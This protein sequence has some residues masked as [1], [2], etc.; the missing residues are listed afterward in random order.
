MRKVSV[1]GVSSSRTG[2]DDSPSFRSEACDVGMRSVTKGKIVTHKNKI[3]T[4]IEDGYFL[5]A[6]MSTD[7]G[8]Y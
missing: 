5:L 3:V 2:E 7:W 4:K 6:L 8:H 1:E